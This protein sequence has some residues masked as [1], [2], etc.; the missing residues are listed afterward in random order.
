MRYQI[1]PTNR[2]AIWDRD[3]QTTYNFA[4]PADARRV[5]DLLNGYEETMTKDTADSRELDAARRELR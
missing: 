1:L 5:C 3:R 4:G 2:L